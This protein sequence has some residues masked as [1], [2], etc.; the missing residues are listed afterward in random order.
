MTTNTTHVTGDANDPIAAISERICSHMNKDHGDSCLAYVRHYGK[1]NDAATATLLSVDSTGMW[2]KYTTTTHPKK[3]SKIRIAYTKPKIAASE[4]RPI[5]ID[6]SKVAMEALG[7]PIV[8]HNDSPAPSTTKTQSSA[9]KRSTRFVHPI[10][11]LILL[12]G[13]VVLYYSSF[14]IPFP[15]A[16]AFLEPLRALGLFVFGSEANLLMVLWVAI[17][18]HVAESLYAQTLFS[19]RGIQSIST[20]LLWTTCILMFGYGSLSQLIAVPVQ[21]KMQ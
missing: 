12:L 20:R 8:D 1:Q 13:L 17:G 4:I 10:L 11:G 21:K 18:L 3:E 5:L 2:L 19:A 15:T 14:S 16:L 9:P 6:M 7:I